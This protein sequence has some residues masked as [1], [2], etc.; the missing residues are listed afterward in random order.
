[1]EFQDG[2][3]GLALFP[4]LVCSPPFITLPA[5]QQAVTGHVGDHNT[6][7]VSDVTDENYLEM[8]ETKAWS[9]S[10]HSVLAATDHSVM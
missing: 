4:Q 7:Y 10:L 2:H 8:Q 9:K 3:N 5:F 1:M 6:C